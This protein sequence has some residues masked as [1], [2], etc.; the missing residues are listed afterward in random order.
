MSHRSL[1]RLVHPGYEPSLVAQPRGNAAQR[2]G[3]VGLMEPRNWRNTT[4]HHRHHPRRQTA[5]RH[6]GLAFHTLS[7]LKDY[8]INWTT[9]S[10]PTHCCAAVSLSVDNS[11]EANA[12]RNSVPI[13]IRS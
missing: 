3:D 10:R 11:R 8:W 9:R 1:Y 13:V 12:L 6:R 2:L 7:E 4:A 5:Q